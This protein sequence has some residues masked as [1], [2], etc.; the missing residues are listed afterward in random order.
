MCFADN[1]IGTVNTLWRCW[2][3]ELPG[4]VVTDVLGC[5]DPVHLYPCRALDGTTVVVHGPT[6][7]EV[8]VEVKLLVAAVARHLV[9]GNKS[10]Q[11]KY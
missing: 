7:V 2:R 8:P 1:N 4:G 5:R 9:I 6:A 11:C 3:C 10:S